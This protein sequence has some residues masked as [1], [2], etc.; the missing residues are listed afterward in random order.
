M[1]TLSMRASIALTAL[2][3]ATMAV[4]APRRA[5]A[6]DRL[7]PVAELAAG[8]LMFADD[9]VVTEGMIGGA[10]RFYVQPRI[11][12][13]PEIALIQGGN[14]SHLMLTG[15]VTCDLVR[16]VDGQPKTVTPFVVVGA[17]LFRTRDT[18]PNREVFTSTEGAF[19]AGGG[20]RAVVGRSVTIGAEARVGWELHIRLNGIVGV[21]LGR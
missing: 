7:P 14:H 12:L 6:Q 13:G 3:S 2:A 11:S 20:V 4:A 1:N 17:G 18:F 10:G 5:S 16:P 9:G 21:R 8:V 15:N 19:T